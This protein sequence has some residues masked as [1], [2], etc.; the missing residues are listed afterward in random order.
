M[1]QIF[2][3][4]DEKLRNMFFELSSRSDVA[5]MLEINERSLRYFLY[6][7]KT[8]NM[9]INFTIP[10]KGGGVREISAPSKELKTIQRKLA[11][12][13]SLVY[14][15]K[16][17]AYGFV[18]TKNIK[19]N[20]KNHIRK[21]VILNI[22]LKNFFNQIHLGRIIGMLKNK[23]YCIGQEA[24][25]VIAQIACCG[26]VLP[27]GAPSS[28]I[29]TNMICSPLDTQLTK[30]AKKYDL[31]YTRYADDITFSTFRAD[32]PKGIVSDKEK[33]ELGKE[34]TDL[35]NKNSFSVNPNKIFINNNEV[36]QE[37]T[38]LVVNRFP[39]VKREY[40]KNLRSILYRSSKD[41]IYETARIYV[42]KGF[43]KNKSIIENLDDIE[44]R[45]KIE[46][47]FKAVLKGK[48]NFIKEVRG[49]K[50]FIYLK[51]ANELNKLFNEEIFNVDY[52]NHI[53]NVI[54]YNVIVL[55]CTD[56]EVQGS[57]F[58]L[59]D[60]GLV[61]S[62]HVI[63][64]KL[65]Y[66]MI[67]YKGERLGKLYKQAQEISSDRDIDYAIYKV[68]NEKMEGLQLGDS[69]KVEI[70]DKVTFIGYPDYLKEDTPYINSCFITSNTR[71]HGAPLYTVS[72]QIFHGTSGGV[73]L[74]KD[75][76]VIGIIKAGVQ[77][78]NDDEG[79]QG[80]Y[81][82]VPINFVIKHLKDETVKGAV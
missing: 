51:Y 35:L 25:T 68:K 44:S 13:L 23:P 6:G 47:W 26:G 33:L 82:F 30:L 73:V 34:L 61:T 64:K 74:D 50:D 15:V 36:R 43:C 5:S 60:Y 8:H 59:K 12:I 52:L 21:K 67:T 32:F 37:V 53:L 27:Q 66:E 81:G 39:N 18:Q 20:A 11:Y 70:G 4:T 7:K 58:F 28:P 31:V 62:Y 57:G 80:K 65:L 3:N 17:S 69:S 48:I 54:A 42:N 55:E 2:S 40:I 19:D 45:E 29:L 46:G 14:R 24:A 41:G 49:N 76:K 56:E 78:F 77:D 75:Y 79:Y 72:A 16:P 22:D 10:K 9:Y 63:E 38:G 1:V 71:Y